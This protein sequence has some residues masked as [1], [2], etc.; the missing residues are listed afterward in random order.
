VHPDS[1][2][3]PGFIQ[4]ARS[5]TRRPNQRNGWFARV[6]AP[7]VQLDQEALTYGDYSEQLME[8]Y[9]HPRNAGEL[10]EADAVVTVGDPAHGDVMRLSLRLQDGRVA[11][12][13]F[14]AFGCAVA[15]AAGSVTT[16]LIQGLSL[17][18]LEDFSDRRVVEALGGVPAGKIGCSVLAERAIREALAICRARQDGGSAVGACAE[19]I[20]GT[21]ASSASGAPSRR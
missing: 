1:Q 12:A 14:K 18:D 7:F 11:E 4:W 16:E 15:I 13:R 20:R 8:H 2:R 9:R 21:A 10:P 17:E 5:G 6:P 3:A 19:S